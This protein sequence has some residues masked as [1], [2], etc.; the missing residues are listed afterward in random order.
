MVDDGGG[1]R[2]RRTIAAQIRRQMILV[3]HGFDNGLLEAL[4]RKSVV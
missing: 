4:D 2:L 1:E 3:V